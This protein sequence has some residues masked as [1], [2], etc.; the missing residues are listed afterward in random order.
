VHAFNMMADFNV[1]NPALEPDNWEEGIDD[2]DDSPHCMTLAL[3]AC[4][5]MGET[6]TSPLLRQELLQTA[7]DD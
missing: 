5:Q 1:D 4:H 7:V 2:D 6:K 3:M